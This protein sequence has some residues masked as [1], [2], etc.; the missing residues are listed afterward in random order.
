MNIRRQIVLMI[1]IEDADSLELSD[2]RAVLPCWQ[3]A[4]A[5]EDEVRCTPPAAVPQQ[6]RQS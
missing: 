1:R 2:F 5:S 4:W 3:V 6:A